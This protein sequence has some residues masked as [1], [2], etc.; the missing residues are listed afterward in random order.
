MNKQ[1]QVVPEKSSPHKEALIEAKNTKTHVRSASEDIPKRGMRTAALQH[2]IT[3]RK[4]LV[5]KDFG[6]KK[7][8]QDC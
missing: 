7:M 8:Y 5:L 4:N 2:N 3:K 1:Q 6:S